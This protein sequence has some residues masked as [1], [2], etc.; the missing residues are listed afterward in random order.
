M[1]ARPVRTTCPYCGVGCG[2]LATARDDGTAAIEGDPAHPANFG[3]LCSKGMALGE[4]LSLDDRLLYPL[5]HGERV[6]WD[7]ALDTRRG[8][9]SRHDRGTWPGCGRVLRLRPTPDRGLLRRQQADE[10][11]STCF[12][13]R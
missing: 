6:S 4:T 7:R 12:G 9:L 3:R 2:V 11:R 1:S 13:T 8:A 10:S 5:V